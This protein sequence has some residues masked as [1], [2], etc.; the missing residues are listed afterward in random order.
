MLVTNSSSDYSHAAGIIQNLRSPVIRGVLG[1][2]ALTAERSD[3]HVAFKKIHT[4]EETSH[5]WN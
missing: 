3:L 1:F 4:S 5:L 2:R